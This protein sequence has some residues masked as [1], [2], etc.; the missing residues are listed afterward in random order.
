MERAFYLLGQKN[1][2]YA[3]ERINNFDAYVPNHV[4][5]GF[6]RSQ[7]PGVRNYTIE[8]IMPQTLNSEWKNDLGNDYIYII[9]FK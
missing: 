5:E 8:H 4:W 7:I 3:L 1:V 9:Y 6:D 2:Q